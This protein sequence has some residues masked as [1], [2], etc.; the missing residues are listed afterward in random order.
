MDQDVIDFI[1]EQEQDFRVST[2]CYGPIIMPVEM[3][4]PKANDL[5]ITIGEHTLY[6]S[7]VQAMY[8]NRITMSMV[9]ER[10]DLDACPAIRGL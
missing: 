7:R 3:K 4:P 9:F 2:S 1:N 8:V 5:R 6:V 10:H